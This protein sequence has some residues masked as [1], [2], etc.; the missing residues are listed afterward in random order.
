M[1]KQLILALFI[2]SAFHG[3]A[4]EI[5]VGSC[6][7]LC[8]YDAAGNRISREYY[9]NLGPRIA[10]TLPDEKA[11]FEEVDALYPNP[12]TG[13]FFITFSKAIDNAVIK[14]TDVNGR[15]VA[16]LKGTGNRIE[17]SLAGKP[18][19]VYFILISDGDRKVTKRI[20][21]Q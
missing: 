16:Q 7:L 6:G 20:V 15:T 2:L 12:T 18:A 14:I 5:P 8:S 21:K 10:T 1:L 11:V 13:I 17:V 9:C 3:I 4:Q 19:G